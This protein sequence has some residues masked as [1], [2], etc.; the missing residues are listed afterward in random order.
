MDSNWVIKRLQYSPNFGKY[1][2]TFETEGYGRGIMRWKMPH[3]GEY[4]VT[5]EGHSVNTSETHINVVDDEI[6]SLSLENVNPL[7]PLTIHIGETAHG[8]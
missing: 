1:L 7:N 3:S 4:T 8:N 5:T 2:L 6:L